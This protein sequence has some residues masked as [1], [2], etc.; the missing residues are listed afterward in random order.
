MSSIG[1]LDSLM[2]RLTEDLGELVAAHEAGERPAARDFRAYAD[3]P[4]DFCREVLGTEPWSKQREICEAVQRHPLVVVQSAVATGKDHIAAALAL[5]ACFARGAFVL[6]TAP[7]DRQ[8]TEIIGG[9]L[10]RHFRSGGLPGELFARALR[11][12]DPHAGIL[13][14]TSSAVDRLQGFHAPEMFVIASEMQGL[15]DWAID[16]LQG[17]AVGDRD[18]ILGLG[19]PL[20]PLGRFYRACQD[21]SGWRRIVITA[22]EFPNVAEGKQIIPGGITRRAIEQ[23]RREWG[24]GSPQYLARIEAQFPTEAADSLVRREWLAAA[25][26]LWRERMQVDRPRQLSAALDVARGGADK[27]VLAIGDGQTV[28]GLYEFSG[29]GGGVAVAEESCRILDREGWPLLKPHLRQFCRTSGTLDRLAHCRRVTV[30]EVGLGAS[31]LDQFRREGYPAVGFN[32]AHEPSDPQAK[33]RML[34][35]RAE[36]YWHV[37]KLLEAG[38]LALPDDERLFE[39]LLATTYEIQPA[40]GKL[41]VGDK[42]TIRGLIGRSPD[43]A[44][45]VAML[46]APEPG[47]SFSQGRARYG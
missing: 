47:G 30:D 39:E 4:V 24:T 11:V 33:Q 27:C 26:A 17:C 35:R 10:R 6:I 38:T 15:E 29:A 44:D 20:R 46:V 2:S 34:N 7:T 8:L 13:M 23:A 28:R 3:R 42:D 1:S 5:W 32:G 22:H 41:K 43:R 21:G 9:H 12:A 14:L 16:A 19:N 31:P 37:R 18:R 25:A 36:S 40:S 45:A